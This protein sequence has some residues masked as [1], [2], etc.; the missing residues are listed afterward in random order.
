MKDYIIWLDSGKCIEGTAELDA[1]ESFISAWEEGAQVLTLWDSNGRAVVK[2]STVQA[3]AIN[4]L[5]ESKPM[6]FTAEDVCFKK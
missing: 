1:L 4:D 3:I 6:G 2:M 5:E